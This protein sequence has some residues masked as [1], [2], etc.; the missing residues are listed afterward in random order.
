MM[1]RRQLS[2]S[3]VLRLYTATLVVLSGKPV[4]ARKP[5]KHIG[6]DAFANGR[7]LKTKPPEQKKRRSLLPS[8]PS[9]KSNVER[10]KKRNDKRE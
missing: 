10:P 5:T 3:T 1:I 7:R 4:I 2:D 6:D 8:V 9:R